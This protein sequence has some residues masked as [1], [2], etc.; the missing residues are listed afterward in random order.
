MLRTKVKL[1]VSENIA[2]ASERILRFLTNANNRKD[3]IE[4]L[5]TYIEKQQASRYLFRKVIDFFVDPYKETITTC[6]ALLTIKENKDVE[7]A[8]KQWLVIWLG[9]FNKTWSIDGA[10]AFVVKQI[11]S[12]F[13]D[14]EKNDKVDLETLVL[15][16]KSLQK[17][18]SIYLK[19]FDE[20]K[21]IN[22][23]LKS[24]PMPRAGKRLDMKGFENLL[25]GV[26][27][28]NR[29]I[30]PTPIKTQLVMQKPPPAPI[31]IEK[32]A[33]TED[34]IPFKDA[35]RVL[36]LKLNAALDPEPV[37]EVTTPKLT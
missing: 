31:V 33:K 20:Q 21:K 35:R 10:E 32:P 8:N 13:N 5:I 6:T 36:A 12:T 28:I 34:S 22:S 9:L 25:G 30:N 18:G 7:V 29:I 26:V 24:S 17:R 23:E 27:N 15:L 2:D 16:N 14:Y 19:T 37:S 11:I 4:W 1:E 3:L